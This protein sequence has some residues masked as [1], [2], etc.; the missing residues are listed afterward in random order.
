MKVGVSEM[1]ECGFHYNTCILKPRVGLSEC[2]SVIFKS[3]EVL[4]ASGVQLMK[5]EMEFYELGIVF[6]FKGVFW[7]HVCV[8]SH[9]VFACILVVFLP[10]QF[11]MY[12]HRIS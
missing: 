11:I 8:Q 9:Y 10:N 2:S 4:L 5:K 7:G 12:L 1:V 3:S 6:I